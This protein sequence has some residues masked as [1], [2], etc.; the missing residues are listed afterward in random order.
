MHGFSLPSPSDASELDINLI[1]TGKR[2]AR[3]AHGALTARCA[4]CPA[5]Q[6]R[7]VIPVEVIPVGTL[8]M[9][10]TVKG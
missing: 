9:E 6:K 10:Q 1:R 4:A 7:E 3:P 8:K 2:C 5:Y